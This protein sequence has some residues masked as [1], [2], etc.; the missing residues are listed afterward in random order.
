MIMV[1]G[2]Y[3]CKGVEETYSHVPLC[4]LVVC[5]LWS[6]V[7]GLLG[8]SCVV[9]GSI[10]DEIWVSKSI[11]WWRKFMDLIPLTIFLVM[12]DFDGIKN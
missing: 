6:M 3:L 11:S 2:C 1:H 4:C 7:Y 9:A 10:R 8:I 12:G 5:K